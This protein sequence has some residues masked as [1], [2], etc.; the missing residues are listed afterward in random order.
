MKPKKKKKFKKVIIIPARSGSKRLKNKNILKIKNK[1]LISFTIS[2]ALKV[3]NIDYVIVSTDNRKYAK[4]SSKC[5]AKIFYLRPKNI[6]KETSTDL[7]LFKFN[8]K[9]L[10]KNLKYYT[11][12]YIHLRPTYPLRKISD[13]N[14]MINIME[15][16]FERIDS[17]RSVINSNIKLEKYYEIGKDKLLRNKY[18]FKR[19]GKKSD[20]IGNHPDKFLKTWLKHNGNIDVF[21]AKI[22]KKNTV[23]GNKIYPFIQSKNENYDI[24]T[25]QD[26]IKISKILVS[27]NL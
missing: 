3:K 11:D 25:K 15:K 5:G 20:F 26:F 12:I 8:E 4:I 19:N 17:V 10:N 7:Q 22:L 1:T 24:N 16:N 18:S 13:I 21:K 23:S 27:K 9:W 2:Q 6:S 14:K